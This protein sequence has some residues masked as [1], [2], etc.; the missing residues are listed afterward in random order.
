MRNIKSRV[1]SIFVSV[2]ELDK[3]IDSMNLFL[4][5]M[6]LITI[7]V[8]LTGICEDLFEHEFLLCCL[9]LSNLL[10]SS[11]EINISVFL[12][13]LSRSLFYFYSTIFFDCQTQF[14]FFLCFVHRLLAM[15]MNVDG[16]R[17]HCKQQSSIFSFYRRFLSRM[18]KKRERRKTL[19]LLSTIGISLL[20][21]TREQMISFINYR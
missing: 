3:K 5:R 12:L 11:K 4:S 17:D 1:N 7:K 18:N 9:S 14:S 8:L 16:T 13:S 19:H 20:L 6:M 10:C 2:N 21:S 15:L